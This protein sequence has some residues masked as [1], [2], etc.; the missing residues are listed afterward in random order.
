MSKTRSKTR[1]T[2]APGL[3]SYAAVVQTAQHSEQCGRRLEARA[4]YEAALHRL[5]EATD[6]SDASNLLRWIARTHR[7][8][9]DLDLTLDC[10]EAALAV[11]EA[12]AHRATRS[13]ARERGDTALLLEARRLRD[14]AGQMH[15]EVR[16]AEWSLAH[17]DFVAARGACDRAR[18]LGILVQDAPAL[19]TAHKVSGI[20]E[21]E[22]GNHALAEEHFGLAHDIGTMRGDVLLLADTA[23]ELAELRRR[24]GRGSEALECLN[25][26]QGLFLQLRARREII[27]VCRRRG[28]VDDDVLEGARR[29]GNSIEFNDE[30]TQGHC[31]RVADIACALAVADGMAGQPLVWF[32]MG[33]LLHDVGKLVLPTE[34]LNKPGQLTPEEWVVVRSHPEAG[35]QMLAEVEFPWDLTPIVQSHHERWDGTGYPHRL[36]GEDIP[37]VARIVCIADVYDALTSDRSYKRAMS[38]DAAMAVMRMD[39]GTQFDPALFARFEEVAALQ[40]REWARHACGERRG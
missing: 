37:R 13:P 30:F 9:P 19:G 14:R 38:H 26:A 25:R 10:A 29:W 6:E 7:D 27:D 8:E 28:S 34:V 20:V 17:G 11:A 39:S 33:A 40:G 35:A 1:S 23:R 22:D 31:E 36:A 24:Q 15:I 12:H 2:P 5:G 32:R 4:L 16:R 3:L 18:L 21:R